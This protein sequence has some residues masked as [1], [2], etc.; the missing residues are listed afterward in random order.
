MTFPVSRP[1]PQ[2]QQFHS[3]AFY[4]VLSGLGTKCVVVRGLTNAV[5]LAKCD[6]NVL[7]KELDEKEAQLRFQAISAESGIPWS[8]SSWTR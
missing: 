3:L 1:T 7:P 5:L 2:T 6:R 4:R 8:I